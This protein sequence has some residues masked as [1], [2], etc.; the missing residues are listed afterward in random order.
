MPKSCESREKSA[1][2]RYI[3]KCLGFDADCRPYLPLDPYN[4]DLYDA[5][6]QGLIPC[7]LVNNSFPEAIDERCIHKSLN[8]TNITQRVANLQLGVTA[9]LCNGCAIRSVQVEDLV[10]DTKEGKCNSLEF[11]YQV[12][13][14]GYF[15]QINVYQHPEICNLKFVGEDTR[16]IK[17]ISP[18]ELLL[19]YVNVHLLHAG[20]SKQICSFEDL[21]DGIVYAYLLYHIA[22]MT[23][24]SRLISP[25]Q[26]ISDAD[27]SNRAKAVLQNLRELEADMFLCHADFMDSRTEL[28]LVT[29]LHLATIAHLFCMFPGILVTMGNH[30]RSR[31]QEDIDHLVTRNF[32][33]SF[34]VTPFSTHTCVNLRDGLLGCQLFEVLRPGSSIGLKFIR[35]FD[36]E[37]IES[38]Y[39]HNNTNIVRLVQ[40]YPLHLP[41]IDSERLSKTDEAC[42]MSL[43]LEIKRAYISNDHYDEAAL[44]RWV[45]EQLHRAG[46]SVE[47][48]SFSDRAIPEENLFAIVLNNLTNGMARKEMMTGKRTENARYYI[49]IAHKAGYPVF[50]SPEHF[51]SCNSKFVTLAFATLRSPIRVLH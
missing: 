1:Y 34:G 28:D 42:C 51:A 25:D 46:R 29:R 18:Q 40:S 4:E 36:P 8:I 12:I 19:R 14:N 17:C 9:A 5:I 7:K 30:S 49:S 27:L 6:R 47:L 20:I 38:Q 24:R 50:T 35:E 15:R 21:C 45:N 33:N 2:S 48:R 44:L 43:L 32:V 11:V 41:H 10:S 31:L 22:P 13:I 26:I 23:L 39:I 3:N 37:R 16:D